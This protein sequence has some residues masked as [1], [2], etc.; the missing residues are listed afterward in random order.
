MTVAQR[1]ST[2]RESKAAKRVAKKSKIRQ[3]NSVRLTVRD[4]Q[5]LRDVM[6]GEANLTRYTGEEYLKKLEN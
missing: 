3:D 1:S 2:R 5:A 4:K 6:T